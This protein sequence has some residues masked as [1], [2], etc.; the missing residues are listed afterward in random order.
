MSSRS[1]RRRQNDSTS[2]YETF[3]QIIIPWGIHQ[4]GEAS[5]KLPFFEESSG[6]K[7]AYVLLR[8]II[9]VLENGGIAVLD[10]IDS[11]LHLHMLV[12]LIELFKYPHTN[13]HNAQLLFSG[14]ARPA[15]T[16]P[17]VTLSCQPQF[18]VLR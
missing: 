4:D 1:L 10:E 9:P 2:Q 16:Q 12:K 11:D 14:L 7:S 18:F 5:F 13:P 3:T 6:T 15:G 8:T 17:R